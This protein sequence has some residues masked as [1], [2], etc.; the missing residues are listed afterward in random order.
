MEALARRGIKSELDGMPA[1]IHIGAGGGMDSG[2]WVQG[3]PYNAD[4][5]S[6]GASIEADVVSRTGSRHVVA[7]GYGHAVEASAC[8]P[9]AE[10]FADAVAEALG[11][12]PPEPV[13]PGPRIRVIPVKP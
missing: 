6:F 1:V 10:R 11:L 8:W 5:R 12:L 7:S 9:A 13:T 3:M 2:G 4:L